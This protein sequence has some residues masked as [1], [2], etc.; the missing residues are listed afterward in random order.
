MYKWPDNYR[1]KLDQTNNLDNAIEIDIKYETRS[2]V[3]K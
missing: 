2:I 3:L 1:L